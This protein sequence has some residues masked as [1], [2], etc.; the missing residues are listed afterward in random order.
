MVKLRLK[1]FG[2][3]QRPVYRIVAVDVRSPREGINYRK[4]GFYDPINNQTYLN[5]L[6]ILSFLKNGA[7]P[8]ETVQDISRKANI[9]MEFCPY[10]QE[11]QLLINDK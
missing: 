6:L 1:R 10:R 7:Q 9:F 11:F 3:K 8:T 5:T 4:V 2:R